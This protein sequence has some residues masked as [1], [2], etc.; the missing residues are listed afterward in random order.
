MLTNLNAKLI[1]NYSPEGKNV[2]LAGR[3]IYFRNLGSIAFIKLQ[4]QSGRIQ[5]ILTK[6]DTES[7]KEVA[8]Q[9]TIGTYIEVSGTVGFSSTNEKSIIAKKTNILQIPV[10]PFPDKWEGIT[11][12]ESK[13]RLRYLDSTLNEEVKNRFVLRSRLIR[14]FR[15]LF[16]NDDFIEI[17]TPILGKH[18]SGAQAKPFQT[19]HNAL[20]TDLFLRIAPELDLKKAV[21][22][23]LDRVFE[24][25]KS[26][27]NEG[28]GPQHMQEFTSLEW[29]VAYADY[30]DNLRFFRYHLLS[31]LFSMVFDNQ[32]EF[33]YQDHTIN[34]NK[35][36]EFTYEEL[37]KTYANI[38]VW[39][40]DSAKDADRI[41]KEQIRPKLIQPTFVLDYP[42]YMS[43][44]AKRSD[45]N[46]KVA[47][48]WQFIVAG[49]E[50]V[51]C[52]TELTDPV[53][54]RKLLE[55]QMKMKNNGD[56]E[57]VELVEDFLEAMEYG[58][59]PMSGAGIGIDRLVA[60]LTNQH[61]LR[62]TILFPLML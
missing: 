6:K 30:K 21:A 15:T 45:E 20:G 32:K 42:A 2:T 54:Q 26:F 29:Y 35:I 27:R 9:I 34:F 56:E 61:N 17:E 4:D 33:Q 23:G 41:F 36:Q 47:E 48:Q 40:L 18:A 10:R 5:I 44:L 58:M 38:D 53:L 25:G 1:F 22:A 52:Y 14:C 60:I 59:P 13:R 3:A 37:F 39:S 62:D 43:P 24:I 8:K 46:E 28:I 55:E 50:I 16:Y 57:A 11:D 31:N 19:H 51:K 7:F 49:M 12:P